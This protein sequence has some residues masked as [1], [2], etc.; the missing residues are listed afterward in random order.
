MTGITPEQSAEA[1]ALAARYGSLKE[2]ARQTGIAFTTLQRRA[3][4]H[5]QENTKPRYKVPARVTGNEPPHFTD[6]PGPR[7]E[8]LYSAPAPVTP[9]SSDLIR[10][11]ALGDLHDDPYLPKDR[12]GWIGKHAAEMQPD[13]IVSIGDICDLESL[14]FHSGN[15]TEAGR[16]K[17]RFMADMQSLDQ[18]LE[19]MFEPMA[20]G[21]VRASTFLTCGNHE[22]RL[23]RFEDSAPEVSGMLQRDFAGVVGKYGIQFYKYGQYLD[24]GGVKFVHSPFSVMGK[25]IGGMTATQTIARQSSGDIVCGH[26]HKASV[27]TAP[28]LGGES[29]VTIIDLG[30]SLPHGYVASY[31]KHTLTGWSWLVWELLIQNGSIQGYNAIPMAEL[32]RKY[33]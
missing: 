33:K 5:K 3:S 17:P 21:N 26:T 18:A 24:I 10:V 9:P 23:I 13:R 1:R 25:P 12:F 29:K 15:A 8:P 2:A 28:R 11:L 19:T 20:K 32:E 7:P 16:Y 30:C 4:R 22:N 14:S 27:I 31:A 6:A